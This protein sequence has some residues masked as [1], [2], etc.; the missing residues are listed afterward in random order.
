MTQAI[1][2]QFEAIQVQEQEGTGFFMAPSPVDGL[3][4][5]LIEVIPVW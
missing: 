5:A 3:I 2:D 4:E 1:I